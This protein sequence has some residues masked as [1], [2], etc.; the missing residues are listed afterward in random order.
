MSM[1]KVSGRVQ[2]LQEA[3]H[4]E[5]K[6]DEGGTYIT[7]SKRGEEAMKL[8]EEKVAELMSKTIE[9]YGYEKFITMI[10]MRKKLHDV[11]DSILEQEN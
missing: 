10:E 1:S 5:W 7:I 8:Q 3:G 11:M 4:V 2:K 6:H 9:I